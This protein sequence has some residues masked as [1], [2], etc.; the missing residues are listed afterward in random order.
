MEKPPACDQKKRVRN[1]NGSMAEEKETVQQALK[2]GKRMLT[3]PVLVIY[4]FMI[5]SW[6]LAFSYQIFF[7]WIELIVI[8]FMLFFVPWVYRSYF[9]TK[10]KITSYERTEDLREL[11]ASAILV[12]LVS[13][14]EGF[15]EKLLRTAAQKQK[16]NEL[17]KNPP[18]AI[19]KDQPDVPEETILRKPKRKY[20]MRALFYAVGCIAALFLYWLT[21][22]NFHLALCVLGC[23]YIWKNIRNYRKNE[24]EIVLNERGIEIASEGLIS[25]EFVQHER[26]V[27]EDDDGVSYYLEFEHPGGREKQCIDTLPIDALELHCLLK[28]YRGRYESSR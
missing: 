25:W 3:Y 7:W 13:K 21:K 28:V 2:R 6:G 4:W 22:H 20:V 14:E 9:L 1:L 12:G 8:P 19:F 23:Y 16:L 11:K 18:V 15:L 10:W 24:P 5:I 17:E 27:R 26:V